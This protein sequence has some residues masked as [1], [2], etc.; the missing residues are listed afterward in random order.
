MF[1]HANSSNLSKAAVM[2]PQFHF[3]F[4]NLSATS[5][6]SKRKKWENKKSVLRVFQSKPHSSEASR[7]WFQNIKDGIL[8]SQSWRTSK[9][10]LQPT[11]SM[12]MTNKKGNKACGSP[13]STKKL[14]HASTV[15]IVLAQRALSMNAFQSAF[16]NSLRE[17]GNTCSSP[18]LCIY[19]HLC[20]VLSAV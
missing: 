15:N 12:N 8:M 16:H 10:R 11:V 18:Y 1:N 14:L 13:V 5:W 7:A 20:I 2:W 9:P 19:A 4:C 17:Y 3:F 6:D